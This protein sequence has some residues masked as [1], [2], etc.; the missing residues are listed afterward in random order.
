MRPAAVTPSCADWSR[1]ALG[2]GLPP[3]YGCNSAT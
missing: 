2:T 1:S 3:A